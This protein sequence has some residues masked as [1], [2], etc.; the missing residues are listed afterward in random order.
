MKVI[1]KTHHSRYSVAQANRFSQWLKFN[2]RN[3]F[4]G[5]VAGGEEREDIDIV[6]SA[7]AGDA[8]QRRDNTE[9]T[10]GQRRVVTLNCAILMQS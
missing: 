3:R 6:E 4:R 8:V 5:R 9:A 7:R 1:W 2:K 10:E